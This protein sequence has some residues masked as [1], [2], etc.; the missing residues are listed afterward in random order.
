MAQLCFASRPSAIAVNRVTNKVYIANYNAFPNPGTVTVVDGTDNSTTT[1]PV[2][3]Q[4]K[5]IIVRVGEVG[6]FNRAGF[7]GAM[8]DAAASRAP[9]VTIVAQRRGEPLSLTL[10]LSAE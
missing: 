4:P 2:G 3:L 1:V 10:A 6:V 8:L 7:L 9:S 5:D